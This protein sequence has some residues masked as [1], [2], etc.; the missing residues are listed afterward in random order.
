MKQVIDI[1]GD[2]NI[3]SEEVKLYEE[4]KVAD[5]NHAISCMKPGD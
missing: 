2:G 5:Y 4:V 1:D 3:D